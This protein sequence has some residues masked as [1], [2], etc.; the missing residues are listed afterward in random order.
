MIWRWVGNELVL[1][2]S[3]VTTFT[4]PFD[5]PCILPSPLISPVEAE[6][7]NWS[8]DAQQPSDSV[9]QDDHT[10]RHSCI[11]KDKK[12]FQHQNK[13]RLPSV[14]KLWFF[15]VWKLVDALG[16][17]CVPHQHCLRKFQT[18]KKKDSFSPCTFACMAKKQASIVKLRFLVWH[19]SVEEKEFWHCI[20]QMRALHL[21]HFRNW[22]QILE[23]VDTNIPLAP[24]QQNIWV[25]FSKHVYFHT[26]YKWKKSFHMASSC[27]S[28]K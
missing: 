15:S 16:K 5:K 25:E 9:N 4:K 2:L 12:K 18:M 27:F 28:L 23:N 8:S 10:V 1:V 13:S 11:W 7:Q 20:L 21:G 19:Y 17:N 24:K 26:V 22:P 6:E 14:G 3:L